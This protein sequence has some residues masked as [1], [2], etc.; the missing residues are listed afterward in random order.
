M[1][2]HKRQ[3]PH[4]PYI[5][6]NKKRY[7]ILSDLPVHSFE[8]DDEHIP[9]S[10]RRVDNEPVEET[11]SQSQ[12]QISDEVIRGYNLETPSS[13]PVANDGTN[14]GFRTT[15]NQNTATMK[16]SRTSMT[17]YNTSD[18]VM[19]TSGSGVVVKHKEFMGI[20]P[21]CPANKTF[22]SNA[23]SL[24]PS[25]VNLFPWLSQIA[26]QYEQYRFKK[27]KFTFS[28]TCRNATATESLTTGTIAI[29]CQYN[30]DSP[31]YS[32]LDEIMCAQGVRHTTITT[33]KDLSFYC[34]TN[35]ATINGPA[36]R[37][38]G[39]PPSSSTMDN[40]RYNLG[41]I[42]IAVADTPS[43]FAGESIGQ[44]FVEYEIELS[45]PRK[46]A[47]S[48][49]TIRQHRWGFTAITHS[50]YDDYTPVVEN[51]GAI[52]GTFTSV[53]NGTT[54]PTHDP[55]TYFIRFHFNDDENGNFVVLVRARGAFKNSTLVGSG[56][57]TGALVVLNAKD[58]ITTANDMNSDKTIFRM[59]SLPSLSSTENNPNFVSTLVDE[60][61][62]KI[63]R[64]RGKGNNYF[65]WLLD[66]EGQTEMQLNDLVITIQKYN[67]AEWF[68]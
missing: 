4:A 68:S 10:R 24:N 13:A 35:M 20:V 48:G 11:R 22:S 59:N 54:Y 44:M 60:F 37:A 49:Y 46:F 57:V 25:N 28:S 43:G 27:L 2:R 15:T 8:F 47:S 39:T 67:P 7:Q 18:P 51:G 16:R 52:L 21:A 62:L 64:A 58:T 38:V 53:L 36:I 19:D 6:R 55:N 32:S 33:Q 17:K 9:R 40:V 26:Q 45:V 56:S 34:N 41:D 65:D 31:A 30:P 1:S 66:N 5:N 23:H 42:S 14:Y 29:A 3:A 50:T 63:R 61:H 12:P